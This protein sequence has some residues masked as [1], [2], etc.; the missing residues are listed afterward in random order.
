MANW[1]SVL[2]NLFENSHIWA[3]LFCTEFKYFSLKEPAF[4][5][6]LYKKKSNI[7]LVGK[8]FVW[9]YST[10]NTDMSMH[11]CLTHQIIHRE[12]DVYVINLDV[13]S[14]TSLSDPT[15]SFL[16]LPA[17]TRSKPSCREVFRQFLQV[18]KVHSAQERTWKCHPWQWNRSSWYSSPHHQVSM[19]IVREKVWLFQYMLLKYFSTY[20]HLHKHINICLK[21]CSTP[22]VLQGNRS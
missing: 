17:H 21:C 13:L 2:G 18:A 8:Q 9:S 3:I 15:F 1:R 7:N 19:Q 6:L 16:L 11:I 12:Y 4:C 5:Q 14:D 10:K 20:T 22:L